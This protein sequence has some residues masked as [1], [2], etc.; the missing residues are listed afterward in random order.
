MVKILLPE[1]KDIRFD[2]LLEEAQLSLNQH[3]RIR[4]YQEADRILI[5]EALVM[6]IFYGRDHWLV[7][8]WVKIPPGQVGSWNL[9]NYIIEP[10]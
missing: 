4:L 8:P 9:K 3:E 7:K 2:K 1:W 5:E 6:P 10:H